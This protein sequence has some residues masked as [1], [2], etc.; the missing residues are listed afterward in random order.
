MADDLFESSVL[1]EWHR[2]LNAVENVP[3]RGFRRNTVV[4]PLVCYANNIIG[5]YFW[6]N[7]DSVFLFI[8][9]GREHMDQNP[10]TEEWRPYHELAS[11]YFQSMERHLKEHGAHST[12]D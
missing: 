3:S 1:D 10:P 7:A 8:Q 6:H 9:R 12:Y 11:D 5:C 4:Y 2:R